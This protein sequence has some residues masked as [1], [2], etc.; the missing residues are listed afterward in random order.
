MDSYDRY[1]MSISTI[2]YVSYSS[3]EYAVLT[4]TLFGVIY[5]IGGVVLSL[6][7][8]LVTKLV[9]SLTVSCSIFSAAFFC[10]AFTNSF[11]QLALIRM[12]MGLGQSIITPFSTRLLSATFAIHYRGVVFGLFNFSIYLAFAL[13]LSLGT[14]MFD[15]YDSFL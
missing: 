13:A 2:P 5:A 6:Q 3:Y 11:W 8:G 4:G 9:K 14:Y 12:T 15:E 1:L 10:T 7:Q